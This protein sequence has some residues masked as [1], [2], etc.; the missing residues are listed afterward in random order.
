MWLTPMRSRRD[1]SPLRRFFDDLFV[2]GREG[3]G[4]SMIPAMDLKETHDAVVIETELPGVDPQ[5]VTVEVEG[6]LLTIRGERR[7]EKEEQARNTYL[8]E[9]TY[10]SFE[11]QIRLPADV[12]RD[13]A[14]AT[15]KQGI[16]KIRLPKK[17]GGRSK[18][19]TIEVK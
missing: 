2:R 17:E 12:D 19:T 7:E 18:R 13:K 15:F 11:R 3:N 16:L 8:Q 9:C 1:D 5:D 14:D 6:D 10:G 4:H